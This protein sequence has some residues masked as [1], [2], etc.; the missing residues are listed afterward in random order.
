VLETTR[1]CSPGTKDIKS[2]F[3]LTNPHLLACL[4]SLVDGYND[5]SLND[6]GTSVAAG[7][8]GNAYVMG[9][10][11][12][13]IAAGAAEVPVITVISPIGRIL[14]KSAQDTAI[15]RKEHITQIT[16][17]DNTDGGAEILYAGHLTTKNDN[18]SSKTMA[19]IGQLFIS[20]GS[21]PI[22]DVV[23]IVGSPGSPTPTSSST[24][25]AAPSALLIAMA[26]G[27]CGFVAIA[28]VLVVSGIML[29]GQR[30]SR[31]SIP[32]PEPP[33]PGTGGVRVRAHLESQD[34]T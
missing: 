25:K 21:I 26:G 8:D 13:P 32:S 10:S 6:Y 27:I 9:Y 28:A 3:A 33:N 20:A 4:F 18:G 22:D 16:I 30:R 5:S 24:T 1:I 12:Y 17:V 31:H 34:N 15:G 19:T 23:T 7:K 29:S 2:A 14:L 11:V